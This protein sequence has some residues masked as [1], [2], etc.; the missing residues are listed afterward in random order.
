MLLKLIKYDFKATFP[1]LMVSSVIYI[2]AS[3]IAPLILLPINPTASII[4]SGV[5][6]GMGVLAYCLAILIFVFQYYRRN[7]Y[8]EE[9]YLM[10]TLPTSGYKLLLSK[11]IVTVIWDIISTIIIAASVGVMI[12]IVTNGFEK[13]TIN[14]DMFSFIS[15]AEFIT[16]AIYGIIGVMVSSLFLILEI[17]FSISVSQLPIW[18]KA[19]TLMGFVTF[20]AVSIITSIPDYIIHNSLSLVKSADVSTGRDLLTFLINFNADFTNLI[21]AFISL[22]FSAGL[23]FLTG[24]LID[25]KISLK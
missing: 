11:L 25:K 23:F 6:V 7:I 2:V 8:G 1:K 3:I 14:F 5:S 17:Y 13:I 10:S 4:T 21:S 16:A 12:Y 24:W 18:G 15:S 9:G 19:G 20:I 22:A